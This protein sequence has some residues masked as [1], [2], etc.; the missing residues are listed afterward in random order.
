M[1]R[2]GSDFTLDRARGFS[3]VELM[4]A[5]AI[6][7]LV[8]AAVSTVMVN[9][10]KNYTVQDS[11][12][13]LQE[14]ARF[15]VDSITRDIRMSGYYGCAHEALKETQNHL[16]IDVANITYNAAAGL[17]GEQDR[18]EGDANASGTIKYVPGSDVLYVR[19]MNGAGRPLI[20]PMTAPTDPITIAP[21]PIAAANRL[22]KGDVVIV[23]DCDTADLFQITSDDPSGTG[24][25]QHATGVSGITPGNKNDIFG[26]S[27][28]P[29]F[30]E[31]DQRPV[32][33]SFRVASYFIATN[34]A[35][36]GR[37]GLY[38]KVGDNDPE[39][40]VEGIESM[41]ILYGVNIDQPPPA[42]SPPVYTP[43]VYVTADNV[44]NINAPVCPPDLTEPNL[45]WREVKRQNCWWGRVSSVRIGLLAYTLA[46]ETESGEYGGVTDSTEYNVNGTQMS[47]EL[48]NLDAK[49]VKRRVFTTTVAVRNLRNL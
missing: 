32:L 37:P 24:V 1:C 48:V 29:K 19:Y 18:G 33:T 31:L 35:R 15:A 17:A 26:G 28:Q 6:G 12:A 22:N 49:R 25:L 30:Y 2:R 27:D 16:D 38:R 41:Q 3:L 14:N 8:L 21:I 7:L 44:P 23:A 4:V 20:A 42:N 34:T 39:E 46:S 13:R 5:V 43:D 10:K 11:L 47:V 36:P 45:E 40:L 9:S